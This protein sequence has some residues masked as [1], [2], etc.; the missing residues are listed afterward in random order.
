MLQN[1]SWWTILG[2]LVLP[3]RKQEISQVGFGR[4]AVIRL[5]APLKPAFKKAS[6]MTKAFSLKECPHHLMV[7]RQG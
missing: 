6:A 4:L 2:I 5:E 1:K 3:F 7:L